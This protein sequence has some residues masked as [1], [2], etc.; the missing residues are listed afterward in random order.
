M[1]HPV[2]AL[3]LGRPWTLQLESLQPPRLSS[4]FKRPLHGA[5][6][7][8]LET[9]VKRG[10][11]KKCPATWKHTLVPIRCPE[12][13]SPGSTRAHRTCSAAR[14]RP[15][16]PS[17][18]CQ[19]EQVGGGGCSLSPASRCQQSHSPCSG[20]WEETLSLGTAKCLLGAQIAL[21]PF[22]N[23]H[24]IEITKKAITQNRGELVRTPTIKVWLQNQATS[25][26]RR[27]AT[28]A[29]TW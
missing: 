27:G 13:K 29:R 11:F 9:T 12:W 20:Q 14:A 1:I 7:T 21:S 23:H 5:I 18:W 10:K 28:R 4:G 8:S 3:L 16:C 6:L 26:P 24:C 2:R 25:L 22:K 15:G 17:P 19:Q